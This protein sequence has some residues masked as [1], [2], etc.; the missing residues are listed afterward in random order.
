MIDLSKALHIGVAAAKAADENHRMIDEVLGEVAEAV[1][2]FTGGKVTL[3]FGD[4]RDFQIGIAM[5]AAAPDTPRNR[6]QSFYLKPLLSDKKSISLG[7]LARSENGFPCALIV[8]LTTTQV[9]DSQ[10]LKAGFA[11]LL[12]TQSVGT[13][14]LSLIKE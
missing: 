5:I 13:S 2:D 10:G 7:Y 9:T 14:I 11:E 8:D 12:S 3:A 1:Q 4:L 6:V